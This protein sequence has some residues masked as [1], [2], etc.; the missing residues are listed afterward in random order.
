MDQAKQT[1]GPDEIQIKCTDDD[2]SLDK[3]NPQTPSKKI[4]S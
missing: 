1:A 2:D 4:S 3:H